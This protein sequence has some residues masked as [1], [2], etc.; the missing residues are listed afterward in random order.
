MGAYT[1]SD[2]FREE[3]DSFNQPPMDEYPGWPKRMADDENPAEHAL[4]FDWNLGLPNK[5]VFENIP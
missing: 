3:D 1:A 4:K 5:P 2:C